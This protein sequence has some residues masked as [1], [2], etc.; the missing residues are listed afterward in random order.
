MGPIAPLDGMR[1]CVWLE[2]EK[3]TP[4]GEERKEQEYYGNKED[5]KCIKT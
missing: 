3:H 5:T 2:G 1:V 4:L